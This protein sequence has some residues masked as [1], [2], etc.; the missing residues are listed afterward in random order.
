MGAIVLGW[1]VLG[2]DVVD[3]LEAGLIGWIDVGRVVT[4]LA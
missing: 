1:S 4:G 2:A 3:W